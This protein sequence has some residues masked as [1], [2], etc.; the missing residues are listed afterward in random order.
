MKPPACSVAVHE[1]QPHT[2]DGHGLPFHFQHA[3]PSPS[4]SSGALS[5]MFSRQSGVGSGEWRYPQAVACVGS[6]IKS[7]HIV[8]ITPD[9]YLLTGKVQLYGNCCSCEYYPRLSF[10]P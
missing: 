4:S 1:W 5:R 10:P 3:K 8:A 7:N 6:G 2:P 9:G